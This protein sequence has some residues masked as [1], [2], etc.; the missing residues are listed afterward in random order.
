M[1]YVCN[2]NTFTFHFC[3]YIFLFF[4][5]LF[6]ISLFIFF[7]LDHCVCLFV[8]ILFLVWICW[9]CFFFVSDWLV[10]GLFW[11]GVG[12]GTCVFFSFS[13]TFWLVDIFT[14]ESKIHMNGMR[15]REL[16]GKLEKKNN[17]ETIRLNQLYTTVGVL[18][19]QISDLTNKTN[20]WPNPL[21]TY[22]QNSEF[23]TCCDLKQ[24]EQMIIRFGVSPWSDTWLSRKSG[25]NTD[26]GGQFDLLSTHW[27]E[28]GIATRWL[29]I[30]NI[31]VLFKPSQVI[32]H[33][34]QVMWTKL[35]LIK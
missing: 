7:F 12:L 27:M 20:S 15:I 4:I 29:G 11:Y 23:Q 3:L 16:E 25:R 33:Q 26:S 1:F 31:F 35:W 19:A 9:L 5:C 21:Q 6:T 30:T 32:Q 18:K 10:S 24:C 17:S 34:V 8:F 2:F 13:C 22:Q 14:N 28:I